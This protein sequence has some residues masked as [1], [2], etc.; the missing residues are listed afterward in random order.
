MNNVDIGF[1]IV[2]WNDKTLNTPAKEKIVEASDGIIISFMQDN[3]WGIQLSLSPGSVNFCYRR[4]SN[5]WEKW[6]I[7]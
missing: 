6:N 3:V 5:I 4:K 7:K 2:R 1:S